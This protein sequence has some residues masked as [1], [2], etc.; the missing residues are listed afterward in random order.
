MAQTFYRDDI[1]TISVT[2]KN[3]DS[4]LLTSPIE[5][6]VRERIEKEDR[7]D[8]FRRWEVR[9]VERKIRND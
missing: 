5:G 1:E 4:M 7:T 6:F 2:F 9:F 8:T 3:G